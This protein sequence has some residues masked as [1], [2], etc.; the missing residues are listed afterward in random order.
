MCALALDGCD[1][2][3]DE[4]CQRKTMSGSCTPEKKKK[5]VRRKSP[6]ASAI[7]IVPGIRG[8]LIP[9]GAS[10][11]FCTAVGAKITWLLVAQCIPRCL[12]W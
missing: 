5:G 7:C 9:L 8:G 3:S 12:K 10:N 2:C 4:M 6:L 11:P 1:H